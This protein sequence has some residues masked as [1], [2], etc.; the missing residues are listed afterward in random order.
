MD[1]QTS[2]DTVEKGVSVGAMS[3]VSDT[4]VVSGAP[5]TSCRPL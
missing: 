3:Y 1:E 2:V 4:T 5:L